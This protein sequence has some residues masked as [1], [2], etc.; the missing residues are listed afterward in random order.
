MLGIHDILV[1]IGCIPLTNGSGSG[2]AKNMQIRIPNTAKLRILGVLLW[3]LTPWRA[4]VSNGVV[5]SCPSTGQGS[6]GGTRPRV[7]PGNSDIVYS[8]IPESDPF[9]FG[10]LVCES[11]S[12]IYSYV[13]GSGSRSLHQQVEKW[14]KTFISTV[15]YRFYNFLSVKNDINVPSKRNEH[16][17]LRNKLFLLA[18]WRSRL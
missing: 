13:S 11:G 6:L 9:V 17:N 2:S 10:P 18:S 12:V 1:R 14:R 3:N 15:L 5:Q 16:K 4:G 8:S 7:A